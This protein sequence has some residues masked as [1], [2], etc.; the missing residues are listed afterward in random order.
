MEKTEKEAFGRL[1]NANRRAIAQHYYLTTD[2]TQGEIARLIGCTDTTLTKWKLEG[3]WE[4][5]RSVRLNTIGENIW[6]I[7]KDINRLIR[8]KPKGYAKEITM[9]NN[10]LKQHQTHLTS[11]HYIDVGLEFI[12]WLKKQNE[13]LAKQVGDLHPIFI[14][15]ILKG[16]ER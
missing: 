2:M 13:A 7:Q 1:T 3:G 5:M 10:Y 6:E 11:R 16:E 15:K 12:G 8:E 14:Q 9:L 4:E